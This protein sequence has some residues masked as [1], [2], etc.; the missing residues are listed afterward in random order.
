MSQRS[1]KGIGLTRKKGLKWGGLS[2]LGLVVVVVGG[3]FVYHWVAGLVY[4]P[5]TRTVK[6]TRPELGV[7]KLVPGTS[8]GGVPGWVAK[9]HLD[10]SADYAWSSLS[11][12]SELAK[13]LKGVASCTLLEKGD[14]WELNKMVLTHPEGAYMRTKT[15]YDNKRKRSHWKMV[16][17]S[18]QAAAGFVRLKELP[19]HPGWCQVDYGYFLKI[20]P[21]LPRN[22]ERPRVQR[23]VRRMAHEIQQYFTRSPQRLEQKLKRSSR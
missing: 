22:F 15:W 23:A 13:A 14:G 21:M 18:F 19:G 7:V 6:A 3:F 16:D 9:F 4:E 17:G 20:S 2:V 12:C 10:V 5:K 1:T 8:P 11:R